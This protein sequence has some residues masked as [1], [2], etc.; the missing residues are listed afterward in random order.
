MFNLWNITNTTILLPNEN[1]SDYYKDFNNTKIYIQKTNNKVIYISYGWAMPS[2]GIISDIYDIGKQIHLYSSQGAS[3]NTSTQYGLGYLKKLYNDNSSAN[4]TTNAWNGDAKTTI[5]SNV[6][7]YSILIEGNL[8]FINQSNMG[9]T[10]NTTY[11][12]YNNFIKVDQQTSDIVN[13]ESY[14][15]SREDIGNSNIIAGRIL[16]K[17]NITF[18]PLFNMSYNDTIFN[19][20]WGNVDMLNATGNRFVYYVGYSNDMKF[21]ENGLINISNPMNYTIKFEQGNLS[22]SIYSL[23]SLSSGTEITNNQAN[24]SLKPNSGVYIYD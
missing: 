21:I 11:I 16:S 7:P 4:I 22:N 1:N 15:I 3:S 14:Q 8:T 19:A 2:G 18:M 24:I 23:G 10:Y 13:W 12:F 5:L 6:Y 20:T 17:N 9:V